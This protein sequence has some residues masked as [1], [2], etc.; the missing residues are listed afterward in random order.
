MKVKFTET[1]SIYDAL[2]V[3]EDVHYVFAASEEMGIEVQLTDDDSLKSVIAEVEGTGGVDLEILNDNYEVQM[4]YT[5][6]RLRRAY[7]S[8][9]SDTDD[10]FVGRFIVRLDKANG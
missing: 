1:G 8:Y 6:Y 4:R 9:A 7:R 10:G 5:G 2:F 3:R